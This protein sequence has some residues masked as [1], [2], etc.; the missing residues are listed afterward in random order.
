MLSKFEYKKIEFKKGTKKL[1]PNVDSESIYITLVDKIL[2]SRKKL[3]VNALPG[4][5]LLIM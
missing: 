5:L 4:L 2:I 1:T 3:L